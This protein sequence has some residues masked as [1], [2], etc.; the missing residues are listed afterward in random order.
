[1]KNLIKAV[2]EIDPEAGEYLEKEVLRRYDE[3]DGKFYKMIEG[4]RIKKDNQ[5]L[6]SDVFIWYPSPWK[7]EFWLNIFNK[8]G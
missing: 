8:L 5:E 6:L 4:K 7:N 2:K 1:M 3:D